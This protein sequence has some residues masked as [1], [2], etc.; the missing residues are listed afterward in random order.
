MSLSACMEI[1]VS[2][3]SLLVESKR[4]TYLATTTRL[5]FALLRT[6]CALLE[7]HQKTNY[8]QTK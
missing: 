5:C 8:R 7:G 1:C 4:K 3:M 6:I 2:V